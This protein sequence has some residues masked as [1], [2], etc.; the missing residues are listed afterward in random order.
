MSPVSP[1]SDH[2]GRTLTFRE[3]DEARRTKTIRHTALS[4]A[5]QYLDSSRWASPDEAVLETARKFE[6][7]LKGEEGEK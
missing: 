3:Q 2:K 5:V 6:T 1:S 7:Y 4:L